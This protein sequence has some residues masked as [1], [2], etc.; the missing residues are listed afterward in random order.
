MTKIEDRNWHG[1]IT[2]VNIAAIHDELKKMFSES[3]MTVVTATAHRDADYLDV[4][5]S[6]NET[7]I[8]HPC[9]EFGFS[10]NSKNYL[11]PISKGFLRIQ[12]DR[13]IYEDKSASGNN[14]HWEFVKETK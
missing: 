10:I 4:K 6:T 12:Y 7:L 14:I 9:H 5:V 1:R 2:T 11:Y 8:L 13:F 3:N